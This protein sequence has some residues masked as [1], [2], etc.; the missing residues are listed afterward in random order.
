MLV[1][2]DKAIYKTSFSHA[3]IEITGVCNMRCTHCRASNEQSIFMDLN[4]I[5]MILEFANINKNDNFNLTISGGEPLMHPHFLEIMNLI[6]SYPFGEIVVTS[7]GSLLT[8]SILSE[9]NELNF[10]NLTI[11]LSLDSVNSFEHDKKRNYVGAFQKVIQ[12]LKFLKNYPKL[13]SSVRMTVTRETI[14][15]IE[16][17]IELLVDLGVSRLGVGSVI[18]VGK[19]AEDDKVL[20]PNEKYNFLTNLAILSRKWRNK[21]EIVT[22]DP[23]KC[24][25]S[26]NPWISEKVY[27]I[28][29]NPIVFGGC[30]AGIDCF[31]VNTFYEITPCSVFNEPLVE[32]IRKFK[33]VEELTKAYE[34]SQLLKK[35]C[36]RHFTGEC[37]HCKHKRICGGC[38]AT[39]NYFG[40]SYFAS[41]KTCWY[42]G[43]EGHGK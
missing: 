39:A 14:N 12:S 20:T 3:Q 34:S 38:R 17:M 9:L 27:E 28:E 5:Q 25:V 24:L 36:L 10:S 35:L 23:L 19:G 40:N 42:R 15:E 7:N 4:T 13:N 18:P 21:I 26:N 32:D 30:T 11:Q 43:G 8:E 37:E 33:N 41:D 31:N 29:S 2:T 6:R 1:E 22:E 16:D